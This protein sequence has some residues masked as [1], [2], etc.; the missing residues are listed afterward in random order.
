MLDVVLSNR[1]KKDLKLAAKSLFGHLEP[2]RFLHRFVGSLAFGSIL[3][4]T[5]FRDL[6]PAAPRIFGFHV[7]FAGGLFFVVHFHR[8]CQLKADVFLY[9]CGIFLAIGPILCYTFFKAF[10]QTAP[11]IFGFQVGIVG[12]SIFFAG[13]YSQYHSFLHLHHAG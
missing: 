11:V 6:R 4:Y 8:A 13:Q 5:L 7:G 3:C 9:R 12:G 1:F 2:H 10:P